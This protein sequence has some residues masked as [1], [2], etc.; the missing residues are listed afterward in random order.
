MYSR[1]LFTLAIK[2]SIAA[3]TDV[4]AHCFVLFEFEHLFEDVLRFE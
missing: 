2:A 3:S 1:P 4:L